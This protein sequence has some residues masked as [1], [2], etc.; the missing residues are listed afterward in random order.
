MT[1]R[2]TFVAALAAVA[3]ARAAG[4]RLF[5]DDF[6]GRRLDT[7]LWGTGT[8]QLGG[9]TILSGAPSIKN[10]IASLPFKT[11]HQT[12]GMMTGCEIFSKQAF[13]IGNGLE[14][15][16]RVRIPNLPKGLVTSLFGYTASGARRAHALSG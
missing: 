1:S 15:S 6:T 7:A 10:S 12:A 4:S 13:P 16:A 8:W 3:R 5:F 14:F 9:R 2:R 11:W